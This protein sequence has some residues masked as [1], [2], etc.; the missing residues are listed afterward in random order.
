VFSQRISPFW[1][2]LSPGAAAKQQG[3]VLASVSTMTTPLDFP[4]ALQRISVEK[5]RD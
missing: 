3:Q 5:R 1:G 4:L 2:V